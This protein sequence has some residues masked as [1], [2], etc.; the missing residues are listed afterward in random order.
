MKRFWSLSVVVLGSGTLFGANLNTT[1]SHGLSIEPA[2]AEDANPASD[3]MDAQASSDVT[4]L[5]AEDPLGGA[6]FAEQTTTRE[7]ATLFAFI[8]DAQARQISCCLNG[9][10]CGMIY[11]S[12][13]PGSVPVS[14]PCT[15]RGVGGS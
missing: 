8:G 15:L 2:S 14:C 9:P 10:S 11:G 5:Y 4:A 13:P 6:R 12:C 3:H 7:S 1:S